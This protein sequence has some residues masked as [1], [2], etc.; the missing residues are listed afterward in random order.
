MYLTHLSLTHFRN[1][2][3]LELDLPA[4]V[5]VIRGDNAQGKTN[6]LEA[7]YYLAT[8]RSPLTATDRELIQWEA[9]DE[10]IP[11]ARARAVYVRQGVEHTIDATLV[12]EREN[13]AQRGAQ[14]GVTGLPTR[15]RRQIEVD[16]VPRRAIDVVG[17]L[18]AVLFMPQDIA[19]VTGSPGDRRRHLDITLCQIDPIYCQ[20]LSRYN[21]VLAQR[22][23]LLREGRPSEDQLAYWD[24]QLTRLGGLIL[25]RRL[26]AIGQL[27]AQ[28]RTAQYNLTG[29]GERLEIAYCCNLEEP[30]NDIADCGDQIAALG[31]CLAGP[32]DAEA[33]TEWFA[34]ALRAAR[35][36]ERRRG[37][38]VVGPHRDDIRFYLDGHDAII[39]GSRGQQRTV[40]LALKLAEVELMRGETGETPVLLLDDILSEL[41]ER[42]GRH[43]LETVSAAQQVLMTTTDLRGFSGEFIQQ[44]MLWTVVAG[45]VETSGEAEDDADVA[46]PSA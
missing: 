3:R 31:A 8:T 40:A 10:V 9:H 32:A 41:D 15:Y 2:T 7:I 20:S 26:W 35:G 43:V 30:L 16:G 13:G 38:T 36:E 12:L 34:R 46:A 37:V 45:A 23:A 33:L 4:R 27:D 17:R 5:H 18:N 14:R 24:A 11:H 29:G 21:R 39:Y 6:L 25:Q 1:Y 28:A 22:N 19:L 42:R 44:A